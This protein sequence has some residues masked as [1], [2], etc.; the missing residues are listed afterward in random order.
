MKETHVFKYDGPFEPE[1]PEDMSVLKCSSCGGGIY[2]G[3]LI[4]FIA[5]AYICPDCFFDFAFDYFSDCLITAPERW[6][7]L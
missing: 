1:I 2:P 6:E 7:E 4:H 5:G 3:E